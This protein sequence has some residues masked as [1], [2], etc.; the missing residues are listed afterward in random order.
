MQQQKIKAEALD[1]YARYFTI[2]F[3]R[4][5]QTDSGESA[6]SAGSGTLVTVGSLH[7]VLTAAHVHAALPK[8]G[9]VGIILNA[10]NPEQYSKLA[11]NMDHIEPIIIKGEEFGPL[12][13]DLAFL[14][15]TDCEALGWLKA[16]NLFYSL[17]QRRDS[18]LS[19]DRPTKTYTDSITGTIHELTKEEPRERRNV[20]RITFRNIFCPVRPSAVR[21]LNTHDLLYVQLATEHEPTFKVPNSF[22]G[23]SGGSVWR[24]YVIEND[25][26]LE[27]VESRLIAVPFHQSLT[28]DGK[29]EI[30]CHG[31]RSIYGSLVDQIRARWPDESAENPV[32][33]NPAA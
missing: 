16:K 4:L 12:G 30:T 20:R 19:G 5:L 21:Y 24:F 18:I 15:L 29:R 9:N 25:G 3:A 22:E 17:S 13:P 23:T 31:S 11:I 32:A 1:R 2:G 26:K 10:E 27:I 6:E 28:P 8:H 33:I 14:R 7:G